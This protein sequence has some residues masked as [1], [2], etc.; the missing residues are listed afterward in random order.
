VKAQRDEGSCDFCEKVLSKEERAE[1]H[2][3]CHECFWIRRILKRARKNSNQVSF[4]E[5]YERQL[6]SELC[7]RRVPQKH[8]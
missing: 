8:T 3:Y 6:W 7:D 1:P 2:G 5:A 4:S